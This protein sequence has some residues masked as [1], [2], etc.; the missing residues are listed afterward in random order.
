MER[1]WFDYLSLTFSTLATAGGL[2]GLFVAAAAYKVARQQGR[3]TFELGILRELSSEIER[4]V[5]AGE[6]RN[7]EHTYSPS[8]NVFTRVMIFRK[9]ELPV[10]YFLAEHDRPAE[11]EEF[12][13]KVQ[14]LG[15]K[16]KGYQNEEGYGAKHLGAVVATALYDDLLK[17]IK[18]RTG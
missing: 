15:D 7:E 16:L 14:E 9:D 6:F 17:A 13:L 10:W 3:H 1:D 18:A 4:A 12:L 11:V 5:A 2:V 8:A